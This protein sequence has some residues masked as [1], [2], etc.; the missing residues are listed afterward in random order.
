MPR[1][2]A[3][4]VRIIVEIEYIGN[5]GVTFWPK[6]IRQLLPMLWSGHEFGHKIGQ[7]HERSIAWEIA[8]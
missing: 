5:W 1:K 2:L 3:K 6:R 8:I 4:T 7:I